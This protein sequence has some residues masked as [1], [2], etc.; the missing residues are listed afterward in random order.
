[1]IFGRLISA[2]LSSPAL[3]LLAGAVVLLIA[4]R[5]AGPCNYYDTGL[6]G[7]QAVRWIQ[8]YSAVP[9]L[10]N[11]YG[12]LGI[13]SSVFLFIAG[14]G[15]GVW[16]GLAH[17]LFGGFMM[18]AFCVTILPACIRVAA[19]SSVSPADW[20]HTVL[21]VPAIFW[22][23]RSRIVGTLT[24]E[25]AA[26]ACLVAAGIFLETFAQS[27]EKSE[28]N[29]ALLAFSLPQLSFPWLSPSNSQL[30][31]SPFSRGVSSSAESRCRTA[32]LRNGLHASS[33]W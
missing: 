27:H 4:I 31:S 3:I 33:A 7:A 24:D 12:R 23:T 6:Y 5:S 20:F 15:Q 2:L 11:L 28:E 29:R 10:A 8:T 26:I 32:P 13:N 21:A 14:I 9:G 16:H 22:A 19:K 25:P 17:H 30:Q 1:V 18:A